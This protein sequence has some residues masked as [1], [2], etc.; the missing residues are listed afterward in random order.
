MKRAGVIMPATKANGSKADAANLKKAA[1]EIG[2][3][4]SR[5]HETS[6]MRI[7]LQKVP[8]TTRPS[9]QAGERPNSSRRRNGAV[10]VRNLEL[11]NMDQSPQS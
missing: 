10:C 4:V 8:R 5:I 6:A 2:Q 1:Q 3:I 9:L 11:A 7:L